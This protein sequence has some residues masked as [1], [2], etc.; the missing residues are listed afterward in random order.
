MKEGALDYI[1]KPFNFERL[2][3]QVA[4]ALEKKSTGHGESIPEATAP[5]PLSL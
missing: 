5:R 1:T 4:K 3:L 2:K